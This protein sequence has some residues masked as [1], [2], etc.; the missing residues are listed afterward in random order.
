[1]TDSYNVDMLLDALDSEIEKQHRGVIIKVSREFYADLV[2]R[3]LVTN[4]DEMRKRYRGKHLML[5]A[6]DFDQTVIEISN[7]RGLFYKWPTDD[8]Q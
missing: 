2:E 7:D 6:E 4:T 8:G 3:D 5:V 1:M